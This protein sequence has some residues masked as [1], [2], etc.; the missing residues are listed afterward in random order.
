MEIYLAQAVRELMVSQA[1]AI[2]ISIPFVGICGVVLLHWW[3]DGEIHWSVAIGGFLFCLAMFAVALFWPDPTV[4]APTLLSMI[5]TVVFFPYAREKVA[6]SEIRR[7]STRQLDQAHQAVV[8]RPDNMTAWFAITSLLYE[9]GLKGPAIAVRE[10]LLNGLSNDMDPIKN[11]S[12][13]GMYAAEER[14]L[15]VW[16][17]NLKG[18]KDPFAPHR[19]EY[20]RRARAKE[21]MTTRLII[22]W[23]TLVG[24]LVATMAVMVQN[25]QLGWPMLFGGILV[26]GGVLTW[27]FRAPRMA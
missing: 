22:G 10:R 23:A 18:K 13:R 19:L 9:H 24:F 21:R 14:M 15:K 4:L 27:V 26:C 25:D 7:I 2:M 6:E 20:A 12:V 11:Q 8:E 5:I 3:I 1:M 16:R 17:R